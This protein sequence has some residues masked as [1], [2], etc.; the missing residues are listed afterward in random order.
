MSVLDRLCL[1]F[2]RTKIRLR[3]RKARRADAAIEELMQEIGRDPA[4]AMKAL[5][6][7]FPD[8]DDT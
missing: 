4:K 2:R 3:L 7:R 8:A 5:R 6:K 1:C